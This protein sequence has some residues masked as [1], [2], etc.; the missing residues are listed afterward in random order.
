VARGT[1]LLKLHAWPAWQ[2]WLVWLVCI[3]VWSAALLTPWP[4]TLSKETLPTD[5]Q[6]VTAKSVHVG[7]YAFLAAL[8]GWL[9][10]RPSY[11]WLLLGFLSLHAGATEFG[12]QFVPE[13]HASWTDVGFDHI[14]VIWGVIVS[15]PWW[16]A[17]NSG[18]R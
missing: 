11:R 12:Q 9:G 13:R 18:D 2:R 7:A 8:S 10:V 17:R 14:G 3:V 15:W 16:T 5:W 1:G 4:A 6:Y